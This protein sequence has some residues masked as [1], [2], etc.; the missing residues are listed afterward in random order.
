MRFTAHGFLVSDRINRMD[1]MNTADLDG[2]NSVDS[3][4]SV[5]KPLPNGASGMSGIEGKAATGSGERG[6]SRARF[7]LKKRLVV[8]EN[9]PPVRLRTPGVNLPSPQKIIERIQRKKTRA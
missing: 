9:E 7:N 5:E 1:K 4:H 2:Q 3:V 6:G 8:G